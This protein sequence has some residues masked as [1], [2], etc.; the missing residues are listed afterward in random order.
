MAS[1]E[2]AL[3]DKGYEAFTGYVLYLVLKIVL[4]AGIVVAFVLLN[5]RA[6]KI[7]K[8]VPFENRSDYRDNQKDDDIFGLSEETA[9]EDEQKGKDDDVFDEF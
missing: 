6:N 9:E 1:F 5:F 7:A 4:L 8:T 3:S 2:N